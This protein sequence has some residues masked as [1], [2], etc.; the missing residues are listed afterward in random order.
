MTCGLDED[1]PEIKTAM[2]I[3]ELEAENIR[4]AEENRRFKAELPFQ[5]A[6]ERILAGLREDYLECR[7]KNS[8]LK[9]KPR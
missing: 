4:L 3:S 5:A 2:L 1:D 6:K 8:S 7:K 9:Q